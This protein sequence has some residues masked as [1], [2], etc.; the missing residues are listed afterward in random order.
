LICV[1]RQ[2]GAKRG[3]GGALV[4]ERSARPFAEAAALGG[5]EVFEEAEEGGHGG[6]KREKGKVKS[7]EWCALG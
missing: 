5:G 7:D 2:V 3:R 6:V 1:F 4:H